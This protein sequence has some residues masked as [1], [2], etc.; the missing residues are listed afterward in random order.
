MPNQYTKFKA[1]VASS[2][3][4]EFRWR[5]CTGKKQKRLRT[6]KKK[7]PLSSP[8]NAQRRAEDSRDERTAVGCDSQQSQLGSL[9]RY[10][11]SGGLRVDP[12]RSFPVHPDRSELA[13]LD[14]FLHILAPSGSQNFI[15]QHKRRKSHIDPHINMLLPYVMQDAH[16]F[17]GLLATCQASIVLSTGLSAYNDRF[18]MQHRGRAMAG[19]RENLERNIDTTAMLSVT[20]L[21]TCDYLTGDLKAVAGHAKALQRMVNLRGELP[22][23]TAWDKFVRRGVEAYKS[24]AYLATGAFPEE[25]FVSIRSHL[26]HD[27]DAFRDLLYPQPPLSPEDCI[28]W[29]QLPSGFSELILASQMSNQLTAIICAID[30]I[31]VDTEDDLVSA[32]H[33]VQPIQAALQRFAQHTQATYLERC[34]AAGL[35][36]YSF[37]HPRLQMPNMFHDPPMQ[38]FIRL[39]SISYRPSSTSEREVLMWAQMSIEGFVSTRTSRLPGSKEVFARALATYRGMEDWNSLQPKLQQYFCTPDVLERWKACHGN[40]QEVSTSE[41]VSAPCYP[42]T[43]GNVPIDSTLDTHSTNMCPFSGH[44]ASTADDQVLRSLADYSTQENAIMATMKALRQVEYAQSLE[45]CDLPIPQAQTGTTIIRILAANVISYTGDIYN[46]IRKYPYPTPLTAGSSAIGRVHS[47]PPDSTSLKEGDLVFIDVTFRSRDD[48]SQ[49]FLSAIHE[50][51]AAGAKKLMSH[52][53]NGSYAE[54]MAVP[55]ENVYPLSEALIKPADQGGMDY[56]VEDLLY[57]PRALVSYGGLSDI[58]IKAG[59]TILIAPATGAFGS[60]AVHVALSM[61]ARVIALGRNENILNQLSSFLGSKQPAGRL[62]TVPIKSDM[63]TQLDAIKSAAGTIPIDAYLDISPPSAFTSTNQSPHFKACI[64]SLRHSGR[65]SLMGGQMEVTLP[66]SRVMHWNL[67][68][69]GKWMFER[70]DVRNLIK[71]VEGGFMVLGE[72]GGLGKAPRAFALEDWKEAFDYAKENAGL[73]GGAYFKIG[74]Y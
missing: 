65:V 48:P 67:S 46:G 49:V 47:L 8:G 17:D 40:F 4:P 63:D 27:V 10:S 57:I 11:P 53:R 14:Y 44:M 5:E 61:G 22:N 31:S 59:Q 33:A 62:I 60:A 15:V 26:D 66:H 21:I 30:Q 68:I 7:V 58:N 3:P 56:K 72:K 23:E 51:Y 12:F 29:S 16:L 52:W 39:F 34:I 9:L 54:Y 25:D 41:K 70:E 19:L 73:G 74:E 2:T 38:G 42:L 55:L 18:F 24:I 6:T 64:L 69:R 43:G 1:A 35:L 71:M 20:M 13:V 28:R 37:Q 45:I 36:A 50:G 32:I